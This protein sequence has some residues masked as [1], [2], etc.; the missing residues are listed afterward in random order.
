MGGN[1]QVTGNRHIFVCHMFN[2]L[3]EELCDW[4]LRS[5]QFVVQVLQ[6]HPYDLY[7]GNN[8]RAKRQRS[9]VVP[10]AIRSNTNMY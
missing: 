5:L 2:S 4:I 7:D 8:E 6:E 3:Q 9:Q 1:S 10:V